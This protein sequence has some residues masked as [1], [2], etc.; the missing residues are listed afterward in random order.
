MSNEF[1][2]NV[3]SRLEEINQRL[4]SIEAKVDEATSFADSVLGEGGVSAQDGMEALKNT[5]SSLINPQSFQGFAQGT[6]QGEAQEGVS[7]EPI[8]DLVS[9]LKMFQDRLTSVKEAMQDLPDAT[10]KG[11]E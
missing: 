5:F 9:S 8:G 3:I 10:T 6:S 7:V 11:D 4:T 1:E 2:K